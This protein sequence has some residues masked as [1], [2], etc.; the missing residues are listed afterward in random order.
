MKKHEEGHHTHW[1]CD[2]V[3]GCGVCKGKSKIP[4]GQYIEAWR[5][6]PCDFDLCIVCMK[7][8][9][10]FDNRDE[11]QQVQQ[12]TD[13]NVKEEVKEKEVDMAELVRQANGKDV[14]L[15]FVYNEKVVKATHSLMDI[16][17]DKPK[18]EAS[19]E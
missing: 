9:K 17:K 5:C 19:Q 2:R 16:A 15:E 3:T 6:D 14:Q 18:E 8:N 11:K 12:K 7:I 4:R 1:G 13:Q 10:W